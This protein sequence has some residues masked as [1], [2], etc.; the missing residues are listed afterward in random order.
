MIAR[1]KYDGILGLSPTL[2][3]PPLG[4][5]RCIQCSNVRVAFIPASRALPSLL[6][7]FQQFLF[8]FIDAPAALRRHLAEKKSA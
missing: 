4:I 1:L 6:A 8:G 5:R 2:P 7:D 3:S